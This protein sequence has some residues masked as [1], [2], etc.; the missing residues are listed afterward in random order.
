MKSGRGGSREGAGRKTTWASGCKQENTKLIRVPKAIATQLL[1]IAHELDAGEAIDLD[2]ES[3]EEKVTKSNLDLK[4][5]AIEECLTKWRQYSNG[6]KPNPNTR[7]QKMREMLVELEAIVWR[8]DLSL[9]S[10]V[11][12]SVTESDRT[13]EKEIIEL[14]TKSNDLIEQDSASIATA[15]ES[16]SL[17]SVSQLELL[18]VLEGEQLEANEALL[19][20]EPFKYRPKPHSAVE[21]AKRL[22]TN[23]SIIK[24]YKS[25][26]HKGS[27]SE[28]SFH[29]D[30]EGF[31][32]KYSVDL[33]KYVSVDVSDSVTKLKDLNL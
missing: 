12:E 10:E 7:M 19:L 23:E 5:T 15:T 30:P 6:Y 1:E 33:K 28:W 25:S 13:N 22:K 20:A 16:E 9:A 17:S 21:L 2:T 31:G 14:A 8:K 26:K 3:K 27:F 18:N 29:R 4:L 24:E 11:L 32:W